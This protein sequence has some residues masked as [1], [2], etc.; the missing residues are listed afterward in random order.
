MT[1]HDL[2]YSREVIEL[3]VALLK[4][5]LLVGALPCDPR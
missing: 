2:I 3:L 1:L 4:L 5:W